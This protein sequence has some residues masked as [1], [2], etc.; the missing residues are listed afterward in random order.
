M[1]PPERTR[2]PRQAAPGITLASGNSGLDYTLRAGAVHAL[3]T[4]LAIVV[5]AIDRTARGYS[6][7]HD[8]Y[9]RLHQAHQFLIRILADLRGVEV[10][11]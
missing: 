6:L 9:D 5:A 8:D 4:E 10:T 3:D 7:A 1:R 2:P 11:T